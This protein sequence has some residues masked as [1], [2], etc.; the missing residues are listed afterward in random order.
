MKYFVL[1]ELNVALM[2]NVLGV[3]F[4]PNIK[5]KSYIIRQNRISQ[6]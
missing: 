4:S 3:R 2:K 6:N 1:Y 5:I